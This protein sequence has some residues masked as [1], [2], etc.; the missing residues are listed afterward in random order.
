MRSWHSSTTTR[1]ARNALL[2]P[3]PTD[4]ARSAWQPRRPTGVEEAGVDS[5]EHRLSNATTAARR[6]TSPDTAR[7]RRHDELCGRV[8]TRRST[9]TMVTMAGPERARAQADQIADRSY[10]VEAEVSNTPARQ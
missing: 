3:T 8:S 2:E 7:D 4:R 9:T 10:E 5:M 1:E 6:G